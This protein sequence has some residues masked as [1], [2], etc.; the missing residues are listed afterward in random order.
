MTWTTPGLEVDE[1]AIAVLRYEF[2]LSCCETR[3]GTFTDPWTH[4]PQPKCGFVICGTEGT[5]SC[6][7]YATTVRVQTRVKPDGFEVACDTLR[8][9]ERDP[10]EYFLYCIATGT[11]LR[12]PLSPEISRIGQQIVDGAV[13]SARDKRTVKLPG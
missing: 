3:W 6:Y 9:P 13:Q 10:V 11:P 12:G 4:Q 7:D 5:V 1:H 8:A 2:G